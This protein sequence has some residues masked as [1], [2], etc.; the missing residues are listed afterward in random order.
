MNNRFCEEQ[1]LGL[2]ITV[3][4]Y[5][6]LQNILNT[7]RIFVTPDITDLNSRKKRR[8]KLP[9]KKVIILFFGSQP[10][11]RKESP[12]HKKMPFLKYSKIFFTQPEDYMT[13]VFFVKI[14]LL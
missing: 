7:F 12:K 1:F 9:L 11:V 6:F 4:L 13:Q 5:L 10:D 2:N 3:S 14:T 8:K